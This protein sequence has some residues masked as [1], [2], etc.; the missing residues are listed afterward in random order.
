MAVLHSCGVKYTFEFRMLYH[1]HH[2]N[3]NVK[4]CVNHTVFIYNYRCAT[5]PPRFGIHILCQGQ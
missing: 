2:I 1:I 3:V 5:S 4:G